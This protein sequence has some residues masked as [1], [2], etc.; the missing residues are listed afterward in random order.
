MIKYLEV[1]YAKA[2]VHTILTRLTFSPLN[3][4]VDVG[5]NPKSITGEKYSILSFGKHAADL[6]K[7][8]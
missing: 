7:K 2:A 1:L 6:K 4:K 3:I 5:R 8:N